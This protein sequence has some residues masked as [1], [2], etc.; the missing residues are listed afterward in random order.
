MLTQGCAAALRS[1]SC[2]SITVTAHV[3]N[4]GPSIHHP[5]SLHRDDAS[6]RY[7]GFIT[8]HN[9][10]GQSLFG[11]WLRRAAWGHA[12]Q[13]K[14]QRERKKKKI[15]SHGFP[16][17]FQK[18]SYSHGAIDHAAQQYNLFHL[19]SLSALQ[20]ICRRTSLAEEKKWNGKVVEHKNYTFGDIW[21][22]SPTAGGI[23]GELERLLA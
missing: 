1:S 18:W 11:V 6:D 3:S 12:V 9:F 22:V 5:T 10:W 23:K 2:L 4:R 20:I 7:T 13:Y 16:I 8:F 14:F 19:T 15:Q 17:G 21:R